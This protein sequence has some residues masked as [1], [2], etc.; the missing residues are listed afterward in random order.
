MNPEGQALFGQLMG[1]MAGK[2]AMGF[3][4]NESMMAMMGGFTMLRLI[5]LAGGMMDMKFTKEQLLE[6]KKKHPN[7]PILIHP[8]CEPELLEI[9]DFIGS[10]ADII[11]F[12]KQS[13]SSEFIVCTEDGVDYKLI[14][15]NPKK[16]FYYPNPHPC[17]ADMKRN[18]LE[19]ILSVLEKEDKEILV[20]ESIARQARKPLDRM[21]AL[22]R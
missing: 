1:G 17:C 7:A 16:K 18:T 6:Q 9:S 10:T 3:E 13:D 20:D 12:A 5:T 19:N 11:A 2:K 4:I 21:L 15:D 22:G 8:E 14:T